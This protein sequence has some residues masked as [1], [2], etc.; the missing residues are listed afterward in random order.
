[1]PETQPKVGHLRDVSTNDTDKT[2]RPLVTE[3][4]PKVGHLRDVN[5]NDT[6]RGGSE[7]EPMSK[8]GT[9]KASQDPQPPE[10]RRTDD[11]VHP[12]GGAGY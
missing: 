10:P 2:G 3:T 8:R 12:A 4:Q 11:K 6:S 1:M 9:T 7:P 5:V